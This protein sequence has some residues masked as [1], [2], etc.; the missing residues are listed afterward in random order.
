M[1][2]N[3]GY[4]IL[5]YRI[6]L[7]LFFYHSQDCC[8]ISNSLLLFYFDRYILYRFIIFYYSSLFVHLFLIS[9]GLSVRSLQDWLQNFIID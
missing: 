2:G 8:K 5:F 9:R 3:L 6:Y 7:L 1:N 4:N